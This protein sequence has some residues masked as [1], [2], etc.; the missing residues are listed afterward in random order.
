MIGGQQSEKGITKQPRIVT[1]VEPPFQ[2]IQI[3]IQMLDR[4]LVIGTD[5]GSLQK[6]PDALLRVGVNIAANP[7]LKAVVD[8]LMARV[9]VGDALAGCPLVNVVGFGI[10]CRVCLNEAVERL[11]ISRV[12]DAE[13]DLLASLCRAY[14]DGLVPL[15][16][17]PLT[18]GLAANIGLV[19]FNNPAQVHRVCALHCCSD[20]M[21]EIPRSLVGDIKRS[22]E[23]EGRNTFARLHHEVDSH[24]PLLQWKVAVVKHG[25]RREGELVPT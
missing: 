11:T 1:V 24:Q 2:L 12:D 21:A 3:G 15:V 13:D 18:P 4:D 7:F 14:H 23:L 10:I 25:A 9:R 20:A 8:G 6:A 16:A 22:F 5:D 19:D 17:T